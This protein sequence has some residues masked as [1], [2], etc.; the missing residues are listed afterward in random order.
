MHN[1][2]PEIDPAQHRLLIHG[3]VKRPLFF[4]VQAL[5]RYPMT[6]RICFIECG[7]NSVR[8]PW[9]WNGGPALLQS[10]AT[11]DQ[12]RVQET[13]KDW[14]THYSPANRYHCNAIQ[15]WSVTAE[16]SIHNVYL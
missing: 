8:I 13:H 1:G 14:A 12:G 2:V 4:T 15:T 11:D 7:G 10:R 3:L 5:L 6:S 16:G 9:D